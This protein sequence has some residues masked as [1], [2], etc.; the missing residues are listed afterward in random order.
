MASAGT[1]AEG[2]ADYGP[3]EL[4]GSGSSLASLDPK[5]WA[6]TAFSRLAK[7]STR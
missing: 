4:D 1:Q 5:I 7:Q 6:L 3:D 2:L